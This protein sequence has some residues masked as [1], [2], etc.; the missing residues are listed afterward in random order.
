M[1]YYSL[2]CLLSMAFCSRPE[3]KSN[4]VSLKSSHAIAVKDS[5]HIN[6][7]NVRSND[8]ISYA[9]T[10]KGIPYKYGS[11]DP[12]VGFDC[13]GFITYVFNHFHITVPRST[14]EFSRVANRIN[15]SRSKPGDLIIFTG[16]DSTKR[17]EG[18]MGIITETGANGINFI[19]STSGKAYSVTT[20]PLNAYYQG[21]YL[22]VIRLFK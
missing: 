11:V 17:S 10:L 22:Y 16:T 21:R 9:Q 14:Q 18:H 4:T 12:N 19:H 7:M 6:T 2:I 20:T 3:N 13:S 5:I 15:V 1:K 8:L